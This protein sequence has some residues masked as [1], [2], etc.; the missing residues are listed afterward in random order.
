MPRGVQVTGVPPLGR[1]LPEYRDI[2]SLTDD[3][4]PR[5]ILSCA[6]GAASFNAHWTKQGGRV[7]SVDPLY[8]EPLEEIRLRLERGLAEIL[9]QVKADPANYVWSYYSGPDAL[10]AARNAACADFAAD[11]EQGRR[12]NRYLAGRLPELPFDNDSFDVALCSHFLFLYSRQPE[13]DRDFHLHSVAE[14]CRVAS[15][16]RL[17]PLLTLRNER[18]PFVDDV[19]RWASTEGFSC[20]IMATRYE[21]QP[22]GNQCLRIRRVSPFAPRKAAPPWSEA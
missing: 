3:D 14:L 19:L 13:F 7:V 8:A 21:V 4:L 16:V 2:F 6:D 18:S 5:R 17:F 20:D 9:P 1:G 11:F 12:E 22:G 10:E 15:D